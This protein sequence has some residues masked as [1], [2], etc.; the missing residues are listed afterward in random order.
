ML[1]P[2]TTC[3]SWAPC[4]GRWP[5]ETLD[6]LVPP[7][8]RHA[9]TVGEGVEDVGAGRILTRGAEPC[10]VWL[11]TRAGYDGE[12][13]FPRPMAAAHVHDNRWGRALDALWSATL[14]R[15]YGA[16]L[17]QASQPYTLERARLHTETTSLKGDGAYERDAAAEGPLVALGDRREH[18]PDLK[19]LRGVS[20]DRLYGC[21][22][23]IVQSSR[24]ES[25]GASGT[26][27][28]DVGPFGRAA[29]AP[30]DA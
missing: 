29:C 12:V 21:G 7:H 10:L 8:A 13:I 16:V 25:V 30:R 3:P 28:A 6:A 20:A 2:S 22:H 17:S 5:C 18:R 27:V 19:H 24:K 11:D 9:V 1:N 26:L 4:Y 15:I 23:I 14:A